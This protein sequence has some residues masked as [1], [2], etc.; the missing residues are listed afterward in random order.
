MHCVHIFKEISPTFSSSNR[1][2]NAAYLRFDKAK[3]S[4][5]VHQ[6]QNKEYQHLGGK[7]R[8]NLNCTESNRL[9][10]VYREVCNLNLFLFLH[11]WLQFSLDYVCWYAKSVKEDNL[12]S[13]NVS[14][15]RHTLCMLREN[16][17]NAWLDLNVSLHSII[18]ELFLWSICS[19]WLCGVGSASTGPRYVHFNSRL[20]R[21]RMQ[22]RQATVHW[23]D[24]A[25]C[26]HRS[27][28]KSGSKLT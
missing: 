11:V 26:P 22:S 23:W 1:S 10:D 9:L 19:P 3:D 12:S 18:C 7:S 25:V 6:A 17:P 5:S 15:T 20:S 4:P 2:F 27:P 28:R 8:L 13:F 24:P 14:D 21:L 16:I